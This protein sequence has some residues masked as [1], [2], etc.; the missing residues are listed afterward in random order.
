MREP[1]L[2]K[3]LLQA[4]R[5]EGPGFPDAQCLA[6]M[7]LDRDRRRIRLLGGLILALWLVGAAGI[8]FVLYE[9]AVHVPEYM[10]M[11]MDIRQGTVNPAGRQ[12]FQEEYFGGFQ[13]GMIVTASS[14]AILALAALGT[15]LL[16]LTTRRATLRQVNASLALISQ[17]LSKLQQGREGAGAPE[18]ISTSEGQGR[19]F[20]P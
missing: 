15:F 13:I 1:E 14:V 19:P 18:K 3:R 17:Q 2:G 5:E 16:V 9:L 4:G 12:R 6:A 7:V 20:D 8:A 10:A 11:Q